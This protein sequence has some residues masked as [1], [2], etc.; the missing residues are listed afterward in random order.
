M[1]LEDNQYGENHRRDNRGCYEHD[2]RAHVR[3]L[4]LPVGRSLL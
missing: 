3:I 4:R 1:A 2:E